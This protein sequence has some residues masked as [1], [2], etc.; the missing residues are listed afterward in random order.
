[1]E[2]INKTIERLT[3][4]TQRTTGQN[5]QNCNFCGSLEHF[6]FRCPICEQYIAEGRCR[7]N[8]ENKVVLPSGIFV[9]RVI[10]G[11]YLK[12]RIDEWHR[13]NPNNLA[14]GHLSANMNT[15]LPA[16]PNATAPTAQMVFEVMQLET[17]GDSSAL[18]AGERIHHLER[19]LATLY[20]R[21]EVFDG[22]ELPRCSARR[23]PAAVVSTE[24][25]TAAP[26]GCED[27]GKDRAAKVNATA[28]PGGEGDIVAEQA[29]STT[30]D[31]ARPEA[32][33]VTTSVPLHP[34][35]GIP[36]PPYAPPV[37]CNFAAP[38]DKLRPEAVYRSL[39]PIADSAKA[40]ALFK[41]CLD[42]TLTV[43]VGELC[44]V[45]P[46][47]RNK[48]KDVVTPKRIVTTVNVLESSSSK[49]EEVPTDELPTPHD[50]QGT[51]LPGAI[52]TSD[53]YETYLNSLRPG[54]HPEQLVVA[55][56]SHS[57]R[58]IMLLVD[59]QERVE[60]I[61]DSGLQII[62]MS[63]EVCKDLS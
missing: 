53:P 17:P 39:A 30:D 35:S 1:M 4:A 34:Y 9:P 26:S 45:A 24:T 15:V 7:R 3:A 31:V 12:D 20:N 10:P 43:S 22:V 23:P 36:R 63:E 37:F 55:K 40:E 29:A 48:V 21:K 6:I 5:G 13:Q 60:A 52:V 2:L 58:S 27:K 50:T 51:P 14:A 32:Q 57:L 41:R 28:P 46:D 47:V 56:E 11:A 49:M 54:E 44:G 62:A 25:P 18:T 42:T 38:P 16:I 33:P 59:I 61:V 8:H 19:E